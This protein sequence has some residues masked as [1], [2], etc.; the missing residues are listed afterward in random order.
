MAA[1]LAADIAKN[2][3]DAEAGAD[4]S[5][6]HFC[7][8]R[9]VRF[10]GAS[11]TRVEGDAGILAFDGASSTRVEGRRGNPSLV[12]DFRAGRGHAHAARGRR[13]AV[14]HPH[15]RCDVARRGVAEILDP[16]RASRGEAQTLAAP[17]G[18][19]TQTTRSIDPSS[20]RG[21]Q[22]QHAQRRFH[23]QFAA[24][25]P[26]IVQQPSEKWTWPINYSTHQ[27]Y[28]GEHA[29]WKVQELCAALQAAA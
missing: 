28:M 13:Q 6:R 10:D 7:S 15:Q 20:T 12:V 16:R 5:S 25:K 22:K 23:F 4:Q 11:S 3:P 27:K 9:S 21:E 18:F 26:E 14:P 17:S 29:P 2:V 24:G 1:D 8:S 19:S